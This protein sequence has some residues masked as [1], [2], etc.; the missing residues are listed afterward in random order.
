MDAADP[1][2]KG[3]STNKGD[4]CQ[5]L[6]TQHREV[7]VSCVPQRFQ[8]DFRE[9]LCTLWIA[10]KVY[11]HKEQVNSTEY[12]TFCL[13]TYHHLLNSFNNES[14]WISISPTV[15]SLLAHG[16]ELIAFNGDMGIGE[17]TVGGRENNKFLPIHRSRGKGES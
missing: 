4:V 16:W 11:T 5:R 6:L 7:L 3:G 2:G 13:D 10:V 14:K 8:S 12:K 9:L 15:H 1:T 17:C